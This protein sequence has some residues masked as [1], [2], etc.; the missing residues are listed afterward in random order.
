MNFMINKIPIKICLG[1]SCF[2]RGNHE[3]VPVIRRY[4]MA[5]KLEDKVS[6]SG[7]HCTKE[8]LKGPNMQVGGRVIHG[9]TKDN[10]CELLDTNLKDL[11]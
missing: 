8:C 10:V 11:L 6:F 7:D 2:S 5:K 1:S 9:I 4:L 3:L